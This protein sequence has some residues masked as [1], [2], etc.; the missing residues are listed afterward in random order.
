[1]SVLLTVNIVY[2]TQHRAA[3]IIFPLNLQIITITRMLSIAWQGRLTFMGQGHHTLGSISDPVHPR[4][5]SSA[6][7]V[8]LA[9]NSFV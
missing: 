9:T 7:D 2:T 8:K 5:H 1:M 3:L 6:P 4:W